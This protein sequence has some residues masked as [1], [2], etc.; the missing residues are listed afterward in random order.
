MTSRRS[1]PWRVW[2]CCWDM[3]DP[4]PTWVASDPAECG[5][6]DCRCKSFPTHA[7][8]IAYADRQ[9]RTEQEPCS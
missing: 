4:H 7:E 2:R 3:D 8:A 5:D 9:A 6:G 1:S